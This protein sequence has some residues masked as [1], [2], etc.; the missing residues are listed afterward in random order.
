MLLVLF[1]LYSVLF[2]TDA[3]ATSI[4]GG[5][6]PF[7]YQG[8]VFQTY[9]RVVGDLGQLNRTPLVVI[10]GG[11]GISH[12]YLIPLAD[13]ASH[14]QPLPVIFYDQ[15]G[16][17][18]STHLPG[19]SPSFFTIDLFVSELANL[20]QQLGI[21]GSF[22]ILGHSWGG[23]LGAEFA[24]RNQPDGLEHLILSDSLASSALWAESQEQLVRTMP[25]DVQEGL[26]APL[27]DPRLPIA[28]RKFQEVHGCTVKPFPEQVQYSLNQVF[29]PQG[30]PTVASAPI[31]QGWTI[32][33]R[34]HLVRPST[35][36]INGANDI[37][38]DFVT[39]P[40]YENIPSVK[41]ITFENSTHMPF[42]EEREGYMQVVGRFLAA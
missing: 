36:V 6:V 30:D 31:L 1:A 7:R 27:G 10:H 5:T 2:A 15:I 19:K 28:M 22:D 33:D 8:E 4:S 39:A 29:P 37:S 3:H 23:V 26:M 18:R 32:I 35:L 13:L 40:F 16:N 38:Q 14:S 9:Y 24:V 11:P 42:W 12:D 34:L 17:G 21:E 41:W 25:R 20:I